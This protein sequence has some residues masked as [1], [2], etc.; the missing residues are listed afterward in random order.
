M[1]ETIKDVVGAIFSTSAPHPIYGDQRQME[2]DIREL[3]YK[4]RYGDP[5]DWD[6]SKRKR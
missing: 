4:Q 5:A 6:K 1:W 3:E 2:R